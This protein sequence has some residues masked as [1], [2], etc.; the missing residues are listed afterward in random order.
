MN[1]PM[2]GEE[3]MIIW[4]PMAEGTSVVSTESRA[5]LDAGFPLAPRFA[6]YDPDDL[7][8]GVVRV[9]AHPA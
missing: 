5:A 8:A 9:L 7:C 2:L 1:T 4:L 6:G 3:F